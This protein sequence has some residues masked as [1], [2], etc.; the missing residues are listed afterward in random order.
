MIT[1]SLVQLYEL[2]S[3]IQ[4]DSYQSRLWFSQ[5]RNTTLFFFHE[6]YVSRGMSQ[7]LEI[8]HIYRGDLEQS[9]LAELRLS[10]VKKS[11]LLEKSLRDI[12]VFF[13]QEVGF[14]TAGFRDA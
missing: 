6:I 5:S 12:N 7:L 11:Q 8:I 13:S 9:S 10:L 2:Y 14:K 3:M 1:L 4:S